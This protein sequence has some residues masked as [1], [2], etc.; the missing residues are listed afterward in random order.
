MSTFHYIP[1]HN[2]AAGKKFSKF[3]KTLPI[4]EMISKTIVRLPMWIG[5]NQEKIIN[6]IRRVI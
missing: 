6:A 5:M 3:R 1:L 4:T 2:S